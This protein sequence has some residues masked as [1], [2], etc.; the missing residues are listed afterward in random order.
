MS[1]KVPKRM[2][3]DVGGATESGQRQSDPTANLTFKLQVS[4]SE[5]SAKDA[6]VLPYMHHLGGPGTDPSSMLEARDGNVH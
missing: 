6:V 5:Q 4:E 1:L 2:L 3:V